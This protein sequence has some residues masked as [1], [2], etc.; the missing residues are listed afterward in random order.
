MSDERL[1]CLLIWLGR[2][3]IQQVHCFTGLY[4]VSLSNN[5]IITSNWSCFFCRFWFV[6]VNSGWSGSNLWDSRWDQTLQC[7]QIQV[8]SFIYLFIYWFTLLKQIF[9]PSIAETQTNDCV[10]PFVLLNVFQLVFYVCKLNGSLPSGSV[11]VKLYFL[12]AGQCAPGWLCTSVRS[13]F[14]RAPC[15]RDTALLKTENT[16]APL[17]YTVRILPAD[18]KFESNQHKSR[19][20]NS[21]LPCFCAVYHALY[22]EELTA[23]ELIRKMASVCCIPLGTINQVYR[24]GPTGIHI[25]LSDQVWPAHMDAP[26]PDCWFGF[27]I[28][29]PA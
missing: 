23:A 27:F 20:Q 1:A 19:G 17:V 2:T 26:L 8:T 15:W 28:I 13:L 11:Q 29:S 22:L 3:F 10:S 7:T 5:D 14:R 6:K 4:T 18:P 16:G 25:L 24:Q 9:S 12:C 21:S